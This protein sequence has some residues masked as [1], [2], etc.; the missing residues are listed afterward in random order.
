MRSIKE[1]AEDVDTLFDK[2]YTSDYGETDY[3]Y[4]ADD[5][6]IDKAYELL[7]ELKEIGYKAFAEKYLK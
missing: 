6:E 1:I 7:H 2:G 5:E 4:E 3:F